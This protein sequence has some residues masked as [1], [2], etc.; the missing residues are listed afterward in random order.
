MLSFQTIGCGRPTERR[1]QEEVLHVNDHECR[2]SGMDRDWYGRRRYGIPR[3]K[4]RRVRLRRM[5]E[6]EPKLAIVQPERLR[7]TDDG[8]SVRCICI[9]HFQEADV[10]PSDEEPRE[11][12]QLVSHGIWECV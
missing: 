6:V 10:G 7:R 9:V 11:G 8:L 2:V 1:R 4:R 5:C 3:L 12:R